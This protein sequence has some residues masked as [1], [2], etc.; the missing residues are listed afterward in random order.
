[1]GADERSVGSSAST[2][3]CCFDVASGYDEASIKGG[4]MMSWILILALIAIGLAAV[5]LLMLAPM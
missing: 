1:M 3:R 4:D 2:V 5:A